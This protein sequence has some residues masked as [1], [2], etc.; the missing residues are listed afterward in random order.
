MNEMS[1]FPSAP[2]FCTIMSTA[3]FRAAILEK[4]VRLAP[5]PIGHAQRW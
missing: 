2:T 3:I 1:A 4:I 5:G